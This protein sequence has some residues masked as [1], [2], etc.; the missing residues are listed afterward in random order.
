MWVVFRSSGVVCCF[1]EGSNWDSVDWTFLSLN[2]FW[3]F[4]P[5][6]N[7]KGLFLKTPKSPVTS[8][9]W[10]W[11][12][13]DDVEAAALAHIHPNTSNTNECSA[14]LV[15]VCSPAF[16][17]KAKHFLM[18]SY[19]KHVQTWGGGVWVHLRVSSVSLPLRDDPSSAY[20]PGN[21][22]HCVSHCERVD[23]GFCG[24]QLSQLGLKRRRRRGGR[25]SGLFD[26]DESNGFKCELFSRKPRRRPFHFSKLRINT[27]NCV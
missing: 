26:R 18:I 20:D 23:I 25:G 16:I 6:G 13:G 5:H 14:S 19:S 21:G 12:T 17:Q 15:L 11:F 2:E 7:G 27:D 8:P 22:F 9:V 24:W 10:L 3:T 1:P 4:Y